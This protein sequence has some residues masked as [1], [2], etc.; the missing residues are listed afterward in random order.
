M[1]SENEP[2][3]RSKSGRQALQDLDTLIDETNT[4]I[5]SRGS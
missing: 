2:K 1:S 3:E 5:Y 4:L